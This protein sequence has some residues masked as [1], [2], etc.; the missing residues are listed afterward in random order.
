MKNKVLILLAIFALGLVSCKK[1]NFSPSQD[2]YKSVSKD[3]GTYRL[4]HWME[5]I[6]KDRQETPL[7]EIVIPG[8][9]DA[10][11][12]KISMDNDW[13]R[14]AAW[15]KKLGGKRPAYFWSFT[16]RKSI[17]ELLEIGVRDFDLRIEHN[18]NGYFSYHG[19]QSTPLSEIIDDY[20]RFIH[21]HPKE[22]VII[23]L[24]C[25]EMDQHE[26]EHVLGEFLMQVGKSKVLAQTHGLYPNSPIGDYWKDGKSLLIHCDRNAVI[27]GVY[28]LKDTYMGTWAQSDYANNVMEYLYNH[29]KT[30]PM[31]KFYSSGFCQTPSASSIV[32]GAF[33]HPKS[34][35][36]LVCHPSKYGAVDTK[37]DE[38]LPKIKQIAEEN[39]KKLNIVTVDFP[40]FDNLSKKIVDMNLK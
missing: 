19:L 20:A 18:D 25:D 40:E 3:A 26:Y 29:I 15:Y 31:D 30:R 24:R 16:T 37:A 27:N 7:N 35:E 39:G 13:A 12:Y 21:A 33:E 8:A 34:L 9:H 2:Q 6:Y 36:D 23:E 5:D 14:D 4:S 10:A 22:I 11:T 28:A 38:W 1:E 32:G 17:Y